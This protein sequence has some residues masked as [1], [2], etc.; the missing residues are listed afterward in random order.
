MNKIMK[1]LSSHLSVLVLLP[2]ILLTGVMTYDIYHSYTKMNNAYSTEYNAFMSHGILKVVH[3]VQKERGITAALLSSKN[4]AFKSQLASQRQTLD[5]AFDELIAERKHWD[6]SKN[7]QSELDSFI[8]K[9]S[10][11]KNIR[12]QVDS[13]SIKLPDAIKFYTTINKSGLHNVIVASKYSDNALIAAELFAVYNLSSAKEYAGVER[14]VL[15]AV[16]A[17]DA[18][19]PVLRRTHIQLI[20]KQEISLHEALESAPDKILELLSTIAKSPANIN[21]LKVRDEVADKN[22]GFQT[23][24]KTW[25]QYATSRIDVLREVEEQ[26][27]EIIDHTAVKIQQEALT[28]VIVEAF[29]MILGIL[30]TFALYLTI[31][32]RK[33]Q[34]EAIAAGIQIAIKD[35]DM[36]HSISI[37]TTDELGKTAEHINELTALFAD[38]LKAFSSA[39]SSIKIQTEETTTTVTQSQSNLITQKAQVESIAAAAEQ[40]GANV[41]NIADSMESN[42]TSVNEV[43]KN[44]QQGQDTVNEAV[45]VINQASDDM[46]ESSKAIHSLNDRVESIS[47]MVEMISSIADQTNLLA[48][49]AAIEAARAGEQGRGFAVVADEVRALASRTQTSTDEIGLIVTQLQ[50]DSSHA[51]TVIEQGQKNATLAS[52]QSEK[53][54]VALDKITNQIQDVQVVTETVSS[55]TQEQASAISEVNVNIS[56]IFTQAIENVEGAEKIAEAAM[57]I[58]ELA[59]KMDGQIQRYKVSND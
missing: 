6:L 32:T 5:G 45:N 50:N 51:F 11:I 39:S 18:Y 28:L 33:K 25:F 4:D 7:M 58:S 12:S 55:N 27:L 38:D 41:A 16:L 13:F 53:I 59:N 30:I 49:N 54:K 19:T 17:N 43:V 3:E 15:S 22:Q 57:S 37:I 20:T 35:K 9:F 21:V 52:E 34:S 48:L 10:N 14:A 47:S 1:M 42:T 8:N 23:S 26:A 46:E 40:M 2:C 44:A 29:I 24:A 56:N 31:K 36:K